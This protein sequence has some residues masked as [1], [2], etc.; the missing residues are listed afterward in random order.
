MHYGSDASAEMA[1]T[2]HSVIGTVKF[3]GCSIRNF[4]GTFSKISLTGAGII[5]T[6]FPPESMENLEEAKQY[7]RLLYS[8]FQGKNRLLETLH[9]DISA[10]RES[11]KQYAKDRKLIARLFA[12]IEHVTQELSDARAEIICPHWTLTHLMCPTGKFFNF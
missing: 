12:N 1:A 5:L 10:L 7:I 2:Y 4:I 8:M 11:E 9:E 6:W 3:H